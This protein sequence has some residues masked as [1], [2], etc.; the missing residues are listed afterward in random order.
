MVRRIFL[1]ESDITEVNKVAMEQDRRAT[2]QI[3]QDNKNISA[4]S[5]LGYY[6]LDYSK[7]MQIIVY[8]YDTQGIIEKFSRWFIE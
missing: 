1:S 4:R 2:I 3:A 6:T 7:P 5:L 8:D